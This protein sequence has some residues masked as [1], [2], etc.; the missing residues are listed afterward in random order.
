MVEGSKTGEVGGDILSQTAGLRHFPL[1]ILNGT[2][3]QTQPYK[4][5]STTIWLQGDV[6]VVSLT[7]PPS[8]AVSPHSSLHKRNP[9]CLSPFGAFE[10]CRWRCAAAEF[11]SEHGTFK[12]IGISDG[13]SSHLGCA[14]SSKASLTFKHFS[15]F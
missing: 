2:D 10:V 7:V 3:R 14:D 11:L 6:L 8:L 5:F 4:T 13:D 15:C 9:S 12:L 1:K